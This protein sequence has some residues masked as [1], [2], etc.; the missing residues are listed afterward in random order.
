MFLCKFLITQLLTLSCYMREMLAC[1]FNSNHS[2]H[3]P[4]PTTHN[5]IHIYT[6]SY[7][8]EV[9]FFVNLI[10]EFEDRDLPLL[11]YNCKDHSTREVNLTPTTK[12][13][14]EGRLGV[15]IRF[16][17]FHDA[18]E[19]LCRV[20]EIERDSPAELAGLCQFTD[21]LLGTAEIG[22]SDAEVL[23]EELSLHIDRTVEFYVY[24]SD[25]DEVR[26]VVVMPNAQWGGEGILGANVAHG[27]LHRLPTSCCA[28]TGIS[29]EISLSPTLGAIGLGAGGGAEGELEAGG[30]R[31]GATCE[32]KAND[33]TPT[34]AH[35]RIA[36]STF[37]QS[38]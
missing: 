13:A 21:Y 3:H 15:A 26:V 12:W 24:N 27:Y 38:P 17:T 34:K 25:T 23:F 11:V 35:Q 1:D 8:K 36:T 31:T 4:S 9:S 16:D 10:K 7:S 33:A 32:S 19:H 5:N 18:E 29:T 20:L 14:G 2:V 28:T 30:V 22:F 6:H 37:G